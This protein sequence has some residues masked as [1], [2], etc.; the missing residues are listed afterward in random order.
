[1]WLDT[2]TVVPRSAT[3]P[4]SR[5]HTCRRI[6][7]SRPST[8]S[9]STSTSGMQLMVSQ[10]AACFCMPLLIRRRGCFSDRGNTSRSL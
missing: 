2:S 3:S 1:M 5:D 6:T 4:S 8:G 9:S 7:G 10:K